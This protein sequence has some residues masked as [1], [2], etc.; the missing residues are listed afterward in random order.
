MIYG[1][2][3]R[4]QS[5]LI[6]AQSFLLLTACADGGS[7]AMSNT[8]TDGMPLV[9]AAVMAADGGSSSG[10]D[11]TTMSDAARTQPDSGPGVVIIPIP[12]DLS[13]QLA[14]T[15]CTFVERCGYDDIFGNVLGEDC[16]TLLTKQFEDA[17]IARMQPLVESGEVTYDPTGTRDCIGAIEALA[18]TIDFDQL[19]NACRGSFSGNRAVGDA[20]TEHEGCGESLYCA[21]TDE[22]PGRCE[23]KGAEGA[24][25]DDTIGC[26]IGL[27][28]V[29]GSCTS[30]ASMGENCGGDGPPCAEGLYCDGENGR[31]GRCRSYNA[32]RVGSG[33]NCDINAGPLCQTGL[34]CIVE[35]EGFSA[36]FRCRPR[37]G[38]GATC[39]PGLPDHCGEG[40]YC[41][42]TDISGVLPDIE[43]ECR[44]LPGEGQPCG[45]APA[46]QVCQNG[47]VCAQNICSARSSLGENCTDDSLCYSGHCESGTCAIE[48]LCPQ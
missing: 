31:P 8:D 41:A 10:F 32:E 9:D 20:C 30:S 29:R 48:R 7:N 36:V 39:A 22:C 46:F 27:Y 28:C 4:A 35:V 34:S 24:D 37:V 3:T 23:F 13:A 43:G 33:A 44:P 18:C 1:N 45:E 21:Q 5:S 16:R 25:C 2:S 11:S 40:L 42:G 15:I 17:D 47:F 14:D 26:E 38:E 19:I 6:I 12:D